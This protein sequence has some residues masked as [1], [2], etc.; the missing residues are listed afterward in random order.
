MRDDFFTDLESEL[1]QDKDSDFDDLSDS[2]KEELIIPKIQKEFKKPNSLPK[3]DNIDEDDDGDDDSSSFGH[4]NVPPFIFPKTRPQHFPLLEQ[5]ATRI[6]TIG[7]HNEVGKNMSMVEYD[8]EIILIDCGIQFPENNMLGAKYSLPDISPI[9][10][11][12]DRI[13]G[14]LVTHGH[15]DH[16]GGLKHVL[17]MLGF[18]NI[19]ATKLTIGLIKKQLEESGIIG[20][21][22]IF[23]INPD[24][25]GIF[26]VGKFKIEFFREN[27]NIPDACG[28]YVE[29]PNFKMVHTGDFKFDFTPSIDQPA[30]LSKIGEIGSRGI[31]LLMSDSTNSMREGF[32]QT[33]ADIG[34]SLHKVISEAKGRV[35]IATFSSLIGRMQQIIESAEKTGR[36]VYLNGRSMVENARIG[37]EL[38]F[39]KCKPGT[40]KRL[41]NKI[42]NVPDNEVLIITTGSQGEEMSGLHRMAYGEHTIINIRPGDTVML[43]SS[44]ILGN[45]R[46][47]VDLMNNLIKFGAILFTKDG[48][49]LHTSGHACREEQKLMLNL[50][51]PKYFMPVHGELYMRVAHKKTATMLG[52]PDKN[53]ILTDNGSI[54]EVDKQRNIKKS[55][56]K[57]KLEEIIVDGHGIGIANSHVIEARA[58]MMKAGVVVIVFKVFQKT[59][60]LD[61]MLKIESRG[62]VYLDEVREVHRMIIKKA[63]T[64]YQQTIKDMPDI[65]DKDLIKII[66][67]DVE[68]YLAYKIDREPMVIPVVMYG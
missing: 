21:A 63:R 11:L 37:R 64:S 14:I 59:R 42:D 13:A 25:D 45:E 7:G 8:K 47:I 27:H 38:G 1:S 57:L 29:T 40:I 17:P 9:I 62:L 53:V 50:I 44:P 6:V 66:R 36:S 35:I 22:N 58:Q 32:T 23:E 16:I 48:M 39:I 43:S 31:D 18:P 33:E 4:N 24:K 20:K 60:E 52:I 46:Q 51:K 34:D 10:P 55:A 28:V 67:K 26:Q 2:N 15:L 5:G 41:T 30:N 49:D 3:S 61:G 65:E 19:Y 12:R 56:F 54:L 68:A